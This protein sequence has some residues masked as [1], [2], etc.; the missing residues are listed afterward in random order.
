MLLIS[1][2]AIVYI[3]QSRLSDSWDIHAVLFIFI[4]VNIF[5]TLPHESYKKKKKKDTKILAHSDNTLNKETNSNG[6]KS[7]DSKQEADRE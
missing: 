7:K 5:T 1:L 2:I 3:I 6:E 4:P